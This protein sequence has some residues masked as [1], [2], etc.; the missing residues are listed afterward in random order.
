MITQNQ[1][2]ENNVDKRKALKALKEIPIPEQYQQ[3]E[4][5][6]SKYKFYFYVIDYLYKYQVFYT[7]FMKIVYNYKT[8]P[9]YKKL[10]PILFP[11]DP[12][13]SNNKSHISFQNPKKDAA[14]FALSGAAPYIMDIKNLLEYAWSK[15]ISFDISSSHKLNISNLKKLFSILSSITSNSVPQ[16]ELLL[17]D[18]IEI[19]ETKLKNAYLYKINTFSQILP[20]LIPEI[21]YRIV[22]LTSLLQIS[23]NP[24]SLLILTDCL[25]S[26]SPNYNKL[27]LSV[28]K[29]N[30]PVIHTTLKKIINFY[31]KNAAKQL[32]QYTAYNI[33][34]LDSNPHRMSFKVSTSTNDLAFIYAD[35]P[36]AFYELYRTFKF[37]K[38]SIEC[39]N[40]L[41]PINKDI[42]LF[43]IK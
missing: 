30:R 36:K 37:S 28:L 7:D 4:H 27:T 1:H 33:T 31:Q 15:N 6:I 22:R 23:N 34:Y 19:T 12:T 13:Y 39:L 26:L 5:F 40:N 25:K 42:F 8:S 32:N 3:Y 10:A 43:T 29:N 17:P 9:V 35:S 11:P 38:M 18:A 20:Y 16:S 14:L 41:I 24:Q 2:T 21:Y